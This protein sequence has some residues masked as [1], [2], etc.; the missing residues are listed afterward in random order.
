MRV[1]VGT[2]GLGA[3]RTRVVTAAGIAKSASTRRGGEACICG[4]IEST[5]RGGPRFGGIPSNYALPVYAANS[6]GGWQNNVLFR[7]IR[8]ESDST[9][10]GKAAGFPPKPKWG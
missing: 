10:R 7:G 1:G 6:C 2:P 9:N 4:A 5:T 8:A 3:R